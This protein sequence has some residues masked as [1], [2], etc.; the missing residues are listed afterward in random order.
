MNSD[1]QSA[2]GMSAVSVVF[3]FLFVGTGA[4]AALG[5]YQLGGRDNFK[6]RSDLSQAIIERDKIAKDRDALNAELANSEGH[7]SQCGA[8]LS[9]EM[10][11][12]R[13]LEDWQLEARRLMLRGAAALKA[14]AVVTRSPRSPGLGEVQ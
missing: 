7:I 14:C 4:I 6:L 8:L 1:A 3:I 12:T 10:E 9:A 13:E 5:G 11:H 2:S